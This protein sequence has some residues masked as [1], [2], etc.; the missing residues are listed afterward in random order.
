MRLQLM[1]H[2][3]IPAAPVAWSAQLTKLDLL[4]SLIVLGLIATGAFAQDQD[5][6]S[7]LTGSPAAMV[8]QKYTPGLV[9]PAPDKKFLPSD[10]GARVSLEADRAKSTR[11]GVRT[12]INAKELIDSEFTA[13][14]PDYAAHRR[15]RQSRFHELRLRLA[16]AKRLKQFRHCSEQLFKLSRVLVEYTAHWSLADA[17]LD[18]LEHS[19]D[20]IDQ[21]DAGRQKPNGA[22]GGCVDDFVFE[23]DQ[24]VDALD[25]LSSESN[26]AP[27]PA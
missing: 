6:E 24:T 23:L 2:F 4:P 16:D 9:D 26:P 15:E 20:Q 3:R 14:D 22:W 1:P 12:E 5:C 8:E 25:Q 21:G 27:P 7:R 17:A 19:L 13:F 18:R 10:F 11:D